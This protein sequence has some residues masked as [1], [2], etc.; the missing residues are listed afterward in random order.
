L[1][2]IADLMATAAATATTAAF[3]TVAALRRY[4][5]QDHIRVE[6][7]AG[8]G[9]VDRT[10]AGWSAT[11]SR[12]SV[13]ERPPRG[14]LSVCV[15]VAIGTSRPSAPT[16]RLSLLGRSGQE[17]VQLFI[18]SQPGVARQDEPNNGSAGKRAYADCI[19]MDAQT[20]MSKRPQYDR[21]DHGGSEG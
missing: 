14:G 17:Q 1:A 18:P 16:L 8:I 2:G 13:T 20:V 15:V 4:P 3:I 5:C 7:E 10:V 19:A 12:K 9:S 21:C 11:N 6:A